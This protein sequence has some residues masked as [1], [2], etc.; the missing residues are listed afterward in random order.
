M[1]P[2]VPKFDLSRVLV[3]GD[4]MLDSYWHGASKRISPEAPVPVVDI[5]QSE[6]RIGGSGNVALNLAS[7]GADVTIVGVIGEDE[8]GIT[9]KIKLDA[10]GISHDLQVSDSKSTIKKLRIIS[11]NQQLLRLDFE[12]LFTDKDASIVTT[13][14][15]KLLSSSGALVL[16]DYGKGS[17]EKSRRLIKLARNK[18]I[19]ILVDPKGNS[20]EVYK[21]ATL[22][23]PN[24]SEFQAVVGPCSSEKILAEKGEKLISKLEIE[25]LLITRSEKGMTLLRKDLPTVHLPA[26][27]R[28][29][30][31]VT[32]AGDTVIAVL[33]AALASRIDI[34]DAVTMANVAAGIVVGKLGTSTVSQPELYRAMDKYR[35]AEFGITND[36]QLLAGITE[37]KARGE[38]IVF[39]NGCFDILHAGHV[40]YLKQ[41]KDNGDRLI[42]AINGDVSVSNLKGPG[43]PIN[44]V[45]Q[46]M[47]VLAGLEAVDWVISF[48]D[49]TP[50]R[51]LKKIKP[52]VLVKGGDY[53]PKEVVGYEIVESYGGEVHVLD[54]FD[55]CSTTKIVKKI[56]E[57]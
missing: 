44:T 15:E 18:K 28:E 17:L 46:R 41:A 36:E 39:T 5:V 32:G 14:A 26:H 1:M 11:Q 13:K 12:E 29:V 4:I 31:D 43:R 54:Y 55:N 47:A 7:L 9:L 57:K 34:L 21:G 49:D 16:S 45:D 40:G 10:A 24:F 37:A 33:A 25:A 35:G 53:S 3:V 38:K 27:A 48:D 6:E 8:D 20:F 23:T 50:N 2:V 52:D 56:Q 42:V 19:P 30:F 22:L 51:L